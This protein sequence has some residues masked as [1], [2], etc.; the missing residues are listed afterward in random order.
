MKRSPILKMIAISVVSFGAFSTPGI[1]FG[2]DLDPAA[3]RKA[4]NQPVQNRRATQ[5]KI[6]RVPVVQKVEVR[7]PTLFVS[8]RSKADI[9]IKG[10]SPGTVK[11]AECAGKPRQALGAIPSD[12]SPNGTVPEN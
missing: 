3:P 12:E 2:Q 11:P 7:I 1:A 10:V 5:P 6:I 9:W 8:A 4:S